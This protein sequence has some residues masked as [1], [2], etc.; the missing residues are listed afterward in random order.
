MRESFRNARME[1]CKQQDPFKKRLS[2]TSQTAHNFFL[3]KST[4]SSCSPRGTRVCEFI[5]EF[6]T[7]GNNSVGTR[8]TPCDVVTENHSDLLNNTYSF[9]VLTRDDAAQMNCSTLSPEVREMEDSDKYLFCQPVAYLRGERSGV[10]PPPPHFF[11]RCS[12]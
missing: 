8:Q 4:P 1:E 10:R 12:R 5:S 9:F 7:S 6:I 11:C 3:N 2:K